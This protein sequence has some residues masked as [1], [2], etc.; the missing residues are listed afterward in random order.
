MFL[1]VISRQ[2]HPE[3]LP[4]FDN[5]TVQFANTACNR[6]HLKKTINTLSPPGENVYLHGSNSASLN[7]FSD[8]MPENRKGCLLSLAELRREGINVKSGECSTEAFSNSYDEH[9]DGVSAFQYYAGNEN[10]ILDEVSLYASYNCTDGRYPVVFILSA[11]AG[12]EDVGSGESRSPL[13]CPEH[14]LGILAPIGELYDIRNRITASG[15]EITV[16]SFSD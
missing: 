16:A 15:L 3:V 6:E 11:E 5:S 13:I 4:L 9:H 8:S 7:M 12:F 1:P 2:S 10:L 14:I